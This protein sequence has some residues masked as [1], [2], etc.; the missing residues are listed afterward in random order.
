MK[1]Y[2]IV[3]YMAVFAIPGMA[4]VSKQFSLQQCIEIALNNN[5]GIKIAEKNVERTKDLQGTAW[6]VDKME[7]S[8]SQDPTSG[9]SPDNAL[10][11]TQQIE[12]PTVYAARRHQLKAE[13][14]AEQSKVG[15][16][17]KQVGAEIASLYWQLVYERELIN[18]LQQKGTY[19]KHY[20]SVTS[21][22]YEIGE[23]RKIENLSAKRMNM[24]N[25]QETATAIARVAAT[26]RKLMAL[27]NTDYTVLPAED[28]LT[29]IEWKGLDYNFMQTA[30]GLY[31]QDKLNVADKAI[32]VAKSGYAPSL[33]LSLRNQL[34]ISS[35]NPYHADR[36]RFDG[37][38]FMGFEVGIGVPLF[39]GATKA[40]VKAAK[41]EKEIAKLELQR[42]ETERKNEFAK[43]LENVNVAQ[44]RANFY[45]NQEMNTADELMRIGS[46]E[47]SNGEISYLEYANIIQDYIDTKQK[48]AA[49]INEYNQAVISLMRMN[50][51]F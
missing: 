38:N 39:F 51:G 41:K 32:K 25:M 17:R 11:I 35:W 10:S 36:A 40:K 19:I 20:N 47:Y 7:L 22:R 27:M 3:I 50:D 33:S 26:Q 46:I 30:E 42:V 18:I 24:D 16:L 5:I 14:K 13:T 29:M 2:V 23:S 49:A 9:G 8:L 15:M 37:G 43:C 34:V 48:C 45:R 12:F 28:S 44:Q 21:K 31:A 4:Q 6:D 1:K